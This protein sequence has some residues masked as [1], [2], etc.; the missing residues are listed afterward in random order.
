MGLW[1]TWS[2]NHLARSELSESAKKPYNVMELAEDM[3]TRQSE[4]SDEAVSG[5]ELTPT[6]SHGSA[7]STSASDHTS[8][9]D[10]MPMKVPISPSRLKEIAAQ[11]SLSPMNVRTAP[12]SF[13]V[14]EV[15]H[16]QP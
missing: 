4:A 10:L 5:E 1:M 3:E 15:P 11:C 9:H 16:N 6:C 12:Q 8:W 7:T 2:T 14:M 13:Q